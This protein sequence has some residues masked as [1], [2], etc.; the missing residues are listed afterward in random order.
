[1]VSA[2]R[3]EFLDRSMP[4]PVVILLHTLPDGSSHYDWLTSLP[5]RDEVGLVAFR[6]DVS[7]LEPGWSRLM[8]V[9]M[10]DHRRLYLKYEG[11]VSGGRGD[12]RRV[13]AGECLAWEEREGEIVAELAFE[14]VRVEIRARRIDR[15]RWELIKVTPEVGG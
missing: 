2:S 9:R 1:M 5:G 12:V 8:A 13:A 7:P 11:A 4:S 15:E 6:L 10:P 14:G 3:V